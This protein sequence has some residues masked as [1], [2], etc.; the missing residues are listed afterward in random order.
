MASTTHE[1]ATGT[2]KE[3]AL[4][5]R[6][7]FF[8]GAVSALLTTGFASLLPPADED[9]KAPLVEILGVKRAWA[10]VASGSYTFD[11]VS[12]KQ[13]GIHVDD[14]SPLADGEDP[15]PVPGATV[16]LYSYYPA[17]LDPLHMVSGVTNDK[18]DVILDI[19]EISALDKDKKPLGGIYQFNGMLEVKSP[20]SR[21]HAMR[22]FSTGLIRVVGASALVVG[23]HKLEDDDE[24]YAE[25][26]CFDDWD[27]HYSENTF[28]RS[29]KNDATHTFSIR[30]L[31]AT[32]DVTNVSLKDMAGKL[33]GGKARTATATYDAETGFATAEFKGEFLHTGTG[34]CITADETTLRFSYTYDGTKYWSDI[35]FKAIDAPIEVAPTSSILAPMFN[36]PSAG[37]SCTIPTGNPI[38]SDVK[39]SCWTPR[40]PLNV[41]FSPTRLILSIGADLV[42][43]SSDDDL[44]VHNNDE[45][46]APKGWRDHPVDYFK[47]SYKKAMKKKTDKLK[48]LKDNRGWADDEGNVKRYNLA[49]KV[50]WNVAVQAVLG[51]EWLQPG[52]GEVADTFKGTIDLIAQASLSFSFT[53]ETLAFGWLPAYLTLCLD[54]SAQVMLM[55]GVK[56]DTA[57]YDSDSHQLPMQNAIWD[58]D[59]AELEPIAINFRLAFTLTLGLG[60]KDVISAGVSGTVAYTMF[61]GFLSTKS[62]DPTLPDPHF[63]VGDEFKVE[64]FVQL[65]IFKASTTL[66]SFKETV[67]D[68][69]PKRSLAAAADE[70]GEGLWKEGEARFMF[71]H[72]GETKPRHTIVR[73]GYN[74][75]AGFTNSDVYDKLV[76]VSNAELGNTT[77][78]QASLRSVETVAADREAAR[79]ARPTLHRDKITKLVLKDD[80]TYE[81]VLVDAPGACTFSLGDTINNGEAYQ[82][83]GEDEAL[84]PS[85]TIESLEDEF[86]LGHPIFGLGT[87]TV[88]EYEY[89]DTSSTTG[90]SC[91]PGGV[92]ALGGHGGVMPTIDVPI[93]RNVFSDPRQRVAVI[94]GTPYLFR[95]ITVSYPGGKNRTRLA[96][97]AYNETTATW[98]APKVLE[99]G[100]DVASMPRIDIYDYDF[101]VVARPEN[102]A[103][104]WYNGTSA[105]IVVTGGLR[106][107]G[108]DSTPYEVFA[109][110]T[111]TM[112]LVDANLNVR[113]SAVQPASTYLGT[114]QEHMVVSPRIVDRCGYN[115][116]SGVFIVAF[117]HRSAATPAEIMSSKATFTVGYVS[118]LNDQLS[119]QFKPLD[120]DVELDPTVKGM[121]LVN[122]YD[123]EGKADLVVT[124]LF[125]YDTGYDV[126]SGSIPHDKDF[127]SFEVKRHVQ[128]TDELPGLVCWP[129]SGHGPFLYT[130]K[131][132]VD[133]MHPHLYEGT[134]S[135]D[136][137]GATS[138]TE[139]EVDL[140]GFK[141][142]A[143]GVSPKGTYLYY[144]DS[145]VGDAGD[146]IDPLTG[147]ATT[148]TDTVYHIT[149]SKF[150]DGAF[151]EDFEF[152]ELEHPVDAMLP[153][154]F[155]NDASS[156]ITT[157][158][159]DADK[160]LATLRYLSVPHI[161]SAEIEGFHPTDHFVC[162]GDLCEFQLSLHNHGNVIIT[163]F[164][165]ELVDS[166]TGERVGD[167]VTVG[168]LKPELMKVTPQSCDWVS[169]LTGSG[170]EGAAPTLCASL[171][172]GQLYPGKVVAYPVSFKIPDTWSGKKT[173]I[174]R[175]VDAWASEEALLAAADDASAPLVTTFFH[176]GVEG[177]L[178]IH[179]AEG[180][181]ELVDPAEGWSRGGNP[182]S[183]TN[184]DNPSDTNKRKK[185]NSSSSGGTGQ[186]SLPKT[187]DPMALTGPAAMLLGG[188][189]AGLAAYGSR[190]QAVEREEWERA[191]RHE[192]EHESEE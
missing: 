143:F 27:I 72:P 65:F 188:L 49:G 106:P 131:S 66:W 159:V 35:V 46:D 6:R 154:S 69:W 176:P 86:T 39:L 23:T 42:T 85:A 182:D 67:Y 99:Y 170:E 167:L 174:I 12:T 125:H 139:K 150:I 14:V 181:E 78:S 70:T 118:A 68:N 179:Q 53:A 59:D 156:F 186:S 169:A 123:F 105:C 184:P 155:G 41:S 145:R 141:G 98:G 91:A 114:G 111:V 108:D 187:S 89:A 28:I 172:K 57:V 149:A 153:L 9:G 43:G 110:P 134:Y 96:A 81:I 77:E 50:D 37:L 79:A 190:R 160:S 137:T 21:S 115:R 80:D 102:D 138:L 64:I 25:R 168:E 19:D 144:I 128:S 173:V 84:E 76:V 10:A 191:H 26:I 192:S 44:A 147:K 56:F 142:G 16:N 178:V 177:E 5:T 92:R 122:N 136:V 7:N 130:R 45:S 157:E 36:N 95:V 129:G 148:V 40:T 75:V 165:A 163:G 162:A 55:M 133:D 126:F 31:G 109:S 152:C 1:S 117:V 62:L 17:G 107:S 171:Q 30:L 175:V 11:I 113:F 20:E 8:K 183:P 54:M 73:G 63:V 140:E 100:S 88:E 116:I 164:T 189:G 18:G 71:V 185:N 120:E 22:E 127:N 33:W 87:P 151:S 13:V 2:G 103:K 121:E 82:T 83:Q 29:K 60:V 74:E 119:F 51:L 132:T 15:V 97:S 34:D 48:S 4:V 3:L 38:F 47:Y 58:L 101:D 166:K 112:L 135:F 52:Q 94:C 93:F 158:I 61:V 146:E 104:Y 90:I 180:D 24:V 161:I 124:M 32:S